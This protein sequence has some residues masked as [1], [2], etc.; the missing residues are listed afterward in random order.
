[1]GVALLCPPWCGGACH[2]HQELI[3]GWTAVANTD[4][5]QKTACIMYGTMSTAAQVLCCI[6]HCNR[7]EFLT[8]RSPC[9][10]CQSSAPPL[11]SAGVDALLTELGRVLAVL[12]N[13]GV[14]HGGLSCSCVLVRGT[15]QTLVGVTRHVQA[16]KD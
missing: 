6:H 10:C 3:A 2:A 4:A 15:D 12:H 11:E 9:C 13:G 5:M 16:A 7:R 8:C 14:V 1:M